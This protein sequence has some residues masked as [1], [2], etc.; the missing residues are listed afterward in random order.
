MQ[1]QG[2]LFATRVLKIKVNTSH[3]IQL[4][5]RLSINS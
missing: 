2:N 3:K 4:Q 5:I 1:V